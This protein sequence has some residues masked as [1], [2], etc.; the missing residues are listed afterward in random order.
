MTAR[1]IIFY[2]GKCGLCNRAVRFAL[3]RD[4]KRNF[5]FA[6]IG[7]KTWT[8]RI[9]PATDADQSSLHLLT[10]SGHYRRSAAVVRLLIGLG[11]LWG[12]VGALLWVI[13]LP[14]RNLGYRIVAGTRYRLFGH[15]DTCSLEGMGDPECL[16]P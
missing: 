6:P 12:V 4:R 10:S 5:A 8:D 11:G 2:D 13:P 7:G 16:L 1:S 9:G 15:A 14:L 3:K